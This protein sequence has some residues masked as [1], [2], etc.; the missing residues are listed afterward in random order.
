M[1]R[2]RPFDLLGA[3]LLVAMGSVLLVAGVATLVEA[4]VRG[5][6]VPALV[7][8]ALLALV[9]FGTVRGLS[10]LRHGRSPRRDPGDRPA[11]PQ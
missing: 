9:G 3:W 6:W 7:T 2:R 5:D 11:D 1:S 4:L 10:Q 8:A